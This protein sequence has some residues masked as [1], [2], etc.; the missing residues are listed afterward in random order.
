M[1]DNESRKLAV[2]ILLRDRPPE[3]WESMPAEKSASG[4][5]VNLAKGREKHRQTQNQQQQ[6]QNTHKKQTRKKIPLRGF[7]LRSYAFY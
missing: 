6:Q 3:A 7:S 5:A 2:V 1:T 4:N